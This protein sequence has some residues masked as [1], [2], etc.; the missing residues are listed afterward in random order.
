MKCTW[1]LKRELPDIPKWEQLNL[2]TDEYEP[3]CSVCAN[4]RLRNPLNA[5]LSMRKIEVPEAQL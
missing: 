2:R 4:R 3:M 1:C 5:L